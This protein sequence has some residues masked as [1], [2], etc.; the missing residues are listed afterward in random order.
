[1]EGADRGAEAGGRRLRTRL[2][3][4][5]ART[6]AEDVHAR[7]AGDPLLPPPLRGGRHPEACHE[8]PRH[9][10]PSRVDP[11]LHGAVPVAA[12]AQQGRHRG[13]PRVRNADAGMAAVPPRRPRAGLPGARRQPRPVAVVAEDLRLH[14]RAL[15]VE[16][17]LH[18]AVH[19]PLEPLQPEHRRRPLHAVPE[20]AGS[21]VAPV[22]GLPRLQDPAG[23]VVLAARPPARGNPRRRHLLLPSAV[24]AAHASRRHACAP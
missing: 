1:M 14:L 15:R 4:G 6:Q 3:V 9:V 8:D 20:A 22:P 16:P 11:V 13:L 12:A 24:R 23:V 5:H 7:G 10:Q 17:G 2:P 21:A 18:G 19:Q